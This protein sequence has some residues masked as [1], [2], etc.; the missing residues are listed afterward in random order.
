MVFWWYNKT[1]KWLSVFVKI[2]AFGS[3]RSDFLWYNKLMKSP[4]P[5]SIMLYEDDLPELREI[6]CVHCSRMLCKINADVKSIVF[7]DGFDPEQHHEMVSG[8]KVMEHK[9]RGCDCVYKF[10][11]Q[12]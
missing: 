12:K 10:L 5:I 8:M 1:N 7:G 6:R 4:K 2:I 11:F 3:A 9:C